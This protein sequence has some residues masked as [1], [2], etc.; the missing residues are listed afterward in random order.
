ME[1][2]ERN[3]VQSGSES[4]TIINQNTY[5]HSIHARFRPSRKR[6]FHL[7]D[8]SHFPVILNRASGEESRE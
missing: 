4:E 5:S 6:A 7:P 8:K 3:A 2:Y 1:A